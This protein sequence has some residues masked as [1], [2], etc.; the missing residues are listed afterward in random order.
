[1]NTGKSSANNLN[2][3]VKGGVPDFYEVQRRSIL[4]DSFK[5][6]RSSG[7]FPASFV[8]Y[9]I[10][11]LDNK[12]IMDLPLMRR[13]QLLQSTVNETPSIAISR[14]IEEYGIELFQVAKKQNLEGVVAKR[15]ESKYYLDSTSTN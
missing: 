7:Q 9:D 3:K 1:M 4:G 2:I 15:K 11:Y 13:K 12:C 10:L 8:A 14:Y 5:L 6:Q